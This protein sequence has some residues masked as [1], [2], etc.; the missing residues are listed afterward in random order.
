MEHANYI[1]C[2]N[3]KL[4]SC[5]TAKDIDYQIRS[6]LEKLDLSNAA[7]LLSGGMDS[8]IL[9]SYMPKG[10]KAY[11]AKCS[12]VGAIDETERAKAYCDYYGLEHVIVDITWD[13]YLES[14]DKLMLRDG[15]PVFANEPQVYKL[16]IEIK[17]SG[18]EL[19]I[20]GDN[21]DMA[22]GGYNRLLSQDWDYE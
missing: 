2:P 14:I 15:C 12:A 17:E 18:A 10:T 22:C 4:I 7:I 20:F 21:A 9:A 8:A 1:P 11:T 6:M 16:S 13:D 19:I 5:E 3:D